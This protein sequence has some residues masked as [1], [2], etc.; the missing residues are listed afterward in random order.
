MDLG[1]RDHS[2]LGVVAVIDAGIGLGKEESRHAADWVKSLRITGEERHGIIIIVPD[3]LQCSF[4]RQACAVR[5][6]W[7][8]FRNDFEK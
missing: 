1:S 4:G 6:D 2:K 5:G 7:D 3:I 8:K